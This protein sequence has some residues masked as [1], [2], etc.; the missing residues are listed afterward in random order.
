MSPKSGAG[1]GLGMLRRGGDSYNE[2]KKVS[3]CLGLKVSWLLIFL[4]SKFPSFK[5]SKTFNILWK[6]LIPY[7]HISISCFLED[8]DPIFQIVTNNKTDLHNFPVLLLDFS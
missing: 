6:I 1:V 3:K 7:Y 2:D 8:F 5:D 4:V